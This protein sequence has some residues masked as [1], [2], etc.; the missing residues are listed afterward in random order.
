[1]QSCYRM[2]AFVKWQQ[3]INRRQLHTTGEHR[4]TRAQKYHYMSLLSSARYLLMGI[5]L[6]FDYS[7]Y[8]YSPSVILHK[9]KCYSLIVSDMFLMICSCK[10]ARIGFGVG[11]SGILVSLITFSWALSPCSTL[12]HFE[13]K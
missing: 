11:V 10:A 4:I 8:I 12:T 5:S 1:M 2:D 7:E 3:L 6:Y 9:A 13:N